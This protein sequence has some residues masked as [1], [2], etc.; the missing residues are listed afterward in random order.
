MSMNR[1]RQALASGDLEAPVFKPITAAGTQQGFDGCPDLHEGR[2]K[3]QL[4]DRVH[5]ACGS[6]KGRRNNLTET[7]PGLQPP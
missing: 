2:R 3:G 7:G 1:W 5:L 6:V 4:I